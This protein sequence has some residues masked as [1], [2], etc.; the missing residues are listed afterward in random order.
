MDIQTIRTMRD[1]FFIKHQQY[2][3]ARAD[4]IE[5][6]EGGTRAKDNGEILLSRAEEE[7]AERAQDLMSDSVDECMRVLRAI[8]KGLVRTCEEGEEALRRN[9]KPLLKYAMAYETI[10]SDLYQELEAK[11]ADFL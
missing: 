9:D 11:S 8:D 5:I 2:I 7:A 10:L 3:E 1:D 4:L 6:T